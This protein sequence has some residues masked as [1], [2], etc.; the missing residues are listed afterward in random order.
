MQSHPRTGMI[1]FRRRTTTVR[2]VTLRSRSEI[3]GYEQ[4]FMDTPHDSL[5]YI[6][7]ICIHPCQDAY[8]CGC[9]GHNFCK[10]CLNNASSTCP[11]CQNEELTTFPNAQAD[12]EI[13]G[14][15]A[16][17]INKEVGCEWQGEL[18]DITNHLENSNGCQFEEVKCSNECGKMLQRQHLISHVET[19]CLHRKVDCRYC[20]IIGEHQYIEGEH[21]EQCPKHPL[22]CPNK[23]KVRKIT[24]EIMQAHRKECP[25]EIVQCGYHNMG[26]EERMMRK[27]KKKH[28]RDKMKEHLLMMKLKWYKEV[29]EAKLASTEAKLALA[30]ATLASAEAKLSLTNPHCNTEVMLHHLIKSS[31]HSRM[32]IYPP[33]WP[34]YLTTMATNNTGVVKMCP[35]IMKM[36]NVASIKEEEVCW[37]GEPFFSQP[38]GGYKM[39]LSVLPAGN[40]DGKGTHMS[41]YLCLMKDHAYDGGLTWPLWGKFEVKLLNQISDCEHYSGI[42][43]FSDGIPHIAAS[44]VID[45]DNGVGWGKPK[46]ISNEALQKVTSTCQY[47]KDDCVF[48]QISK[49]P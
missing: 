42:V 2:V 22:P 11:V 40:G 1:V 29:Y 47:L 48:L 6:C 21:K 18:T 20:H 3:G 15:Y 44:R 35:V 37:Q 14:F 26:C 9:C 28:E 5:W 13:E 27:R 33:Q 17:C 8:I 12:Q 24:R 34:I 10:S 23:C 16:M 25:L 31:G 32:V 4:Q 45:G 39:S 19:E 46:F 36:A 49:L 41:V 7:K 43:L 30:E 38:N